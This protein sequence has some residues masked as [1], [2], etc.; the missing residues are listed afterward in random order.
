MIFRPL[1]ILQYIPGDPSS[2]VVISAPHGGYKK[3]IGCPPRIHGCKLQGQCIYNAQRRAPCPG[4]VCRTNPKMDTGTKEIAEKLADLL[5]QKIG[6]RPHLVIMEV[7][8]SQIDA[9]REVRE[10]CMHC[11]ACEKV[12]KDYHS[13]VCQSTGVTERVLRKVGVLKSDRS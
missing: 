4:K 10:A 12:Y 6:S 11:E 13:K 1:C 5:G 2:R 8:R 9:N 7:H 3:E